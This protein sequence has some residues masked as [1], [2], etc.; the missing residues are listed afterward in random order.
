MEHTALAKSFQFVLDG[1]LR[2]VRIADLKAERGISTQSGG[3][4]I[5]INAAFGVARLRGKKNSL[6][7]KATITTIGQPDNGESSDPEFKVSIEVRGVYEWPRD[8]LNGEFSGQDVAK[9]LC[10][11]VY[12]YAAEKVNEMIVSL[13]IAG[14]RID[15]D[16][17]SGMDSLGQVIDEVKSDAQKQEALTELVDSPQKTV[18]RIVRPKAKKSP[19]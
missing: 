2:R 16:F 13:G 19:K 7:A 10:Q 14:A 1:R 4:H 15:L 12:L 6:I 9:M 5:K 11:S 17:R 3:G 18:K 8:I